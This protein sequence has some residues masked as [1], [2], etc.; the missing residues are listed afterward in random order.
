VYLLA[1]TN[2]GPVG[3][4]HGKAAEEAYRWTEVAYAFDGKYGWECLVAVW[5]ATFVLANKSRV[6][7]CVYTKNYVCRRRFLGLELVIFAILTIYWPLGP[8]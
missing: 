8:L 4:I 3:Q 2:H 7:N 1:A 6:I 5:N